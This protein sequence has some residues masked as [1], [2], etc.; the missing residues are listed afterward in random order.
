MQA[1]ESVVIAVLKKAIPAV[2]KSCDNYHEKFVPAVRKNCLLWTE[3][4]RSD[5]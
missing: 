3:A 1:V 5:G 4:K 2:K